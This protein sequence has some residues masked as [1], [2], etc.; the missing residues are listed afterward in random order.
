V[1]NLATGDLAIAVVA[2]DPVLTDQLEV[3]LAATKP[4]AIQSVFLRNEDLHPLRQVSTQS[5]PKSDLE[6]LAE[7]RQQG[8]STLIIGEVLQRPKRTRTEAPGTLDRLS[9]SWRVVDVASGATLG[10]AP[11]YMDA[12]L[13][14]RRGQGA[15]TDLMRNLAQVSW[16]VVAPHVESS[17][18][19]LAKSTWHLG[20]KKVRE[21]NHLARK[22]GWPEAQRRWEEAVKISARNHAAMH[23]LA[24]AAVAREDFEEARRWIQRAMKAHRGYEE[25]YAWIEIRRKE[26]HDAFRLPDPPD[27]WPLLAR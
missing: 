19:E 4:S 13:A 17:E 12:E 27:G 9:V 6:A 11:A 26:Y 24:L 22:G 7:S 20:A 1:R 14:Q 18:I 8:V 10:G 2:D 21:G 3:A 15:D 25:T 5:R 23:N 16:H